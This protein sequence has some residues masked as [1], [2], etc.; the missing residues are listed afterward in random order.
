M[1]AFHPPTSLKGTPAVVLVFYEVMLLIKLS[2]VLWWSF[3]K[4]GVKWMFMTLSFLLY[5]AC[6]SPGFLRVAYEYTK[7]KSIIKNIRYG[8]RPRNLLD[9]FLCEPIDKE[10]LQDVVI[11]G[12]KKAEEEKD[13]VSRQPAGKPVAVFVSGG[14][15][16]LG[17]KGW[18]ALFAKTLSRCGIIVVTPD[19]R[20]FPQGGASD[21][22]VDISQA[23]KWVFENISLYGGDPERIFLIAQSAGAHIS[24]YLP[25]SFCVPT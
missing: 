7:S 16:I 14:A 12:E 3:V 4:A 23:M 18:G 5:V 9:I 2:A 17:Y 1:E 22:V 25:S 8:E 21:M 13:P 24:N 10:Q 11:E 15:W 6:L 20:N 19:Y